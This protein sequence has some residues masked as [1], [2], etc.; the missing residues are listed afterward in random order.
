M[1]S[2]VL[3]GQEKTQPKEPCISIYYHSAARTR[4]VVVEHQPCGGQSHLPSLPNRAGDGLSRGLRF[5]S[6]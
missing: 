5:T 6:K 2:E 1:V 3:E 4:R